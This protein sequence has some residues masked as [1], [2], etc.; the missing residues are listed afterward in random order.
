MRLPVD[1][2]GEVWIKAGEEDRFNV[3]HDGAH[4]FLPF[5]CDI[6]WFRNL[7]GRDPEKDKDRDKLLLIT[8]RRVNLL[9]M[10]G[11]DNGRNEGSTINFNTCEQ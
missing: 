5:K 10:W 9:G 1:N 3:G 6:C 4:L 11:S 7:K 8:I 2:D